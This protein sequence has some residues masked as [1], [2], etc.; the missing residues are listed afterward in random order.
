TSTGYFGAPFVAYRAWR[1]RD[2]VLPTVTIAVGPAGVKYRAPNG[3]SNLRWGD[4][5]WTR[6]TSRFIFLFRPPVTFVLPVRVLS[7]DDFRAIQAFMTDAGFGPSGRRRGR[8]SG[9]TVPPGL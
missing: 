4:I 6:T 3:S 9:P 7:N 5:A 2:R 8:S 1:N